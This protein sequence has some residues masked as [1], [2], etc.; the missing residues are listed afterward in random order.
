[1]PNQ[2]QNVNDNQANYR[3]SSSN[4]NVVQSRQIGVSSPGQVNINNS[5]PHQ[6][7]QPAPNNS[8]PI[9]SYLSNQSTNFTATSNQ[10]HPI[11]GQNI[12]SPSVYRPASTT[13]PQY[14]A[15]SNTRQQPHNS[16]INTSNTNASI[17]PSIQ[18]NP[19]VNHLVNHTNQNNNN[20]ARY[21]DNVSNRAGS[22]TNTNSHIAANPISDNVAQANTT[23]HIG[24]QNPSSL[25]LQSSVQNTLNTQ[26]TQSTLPKIEYINPNNIKIP[27]RPESYADL[28]TQAIEND[29]PL[30]TQAT[31]V[32]KEQYNKLQKQNTK[33][34]IDTHEIIK[35][36]LYVLPVIA[37][38]IIIF[39]AP[40]A[41][42][43]LWHARQ[44]VIAQI[45]WLLVLYILNSTGAP[46]IAGNGFTLA[47]LWNVICITN[48]VY[49]GAQAYLG[50]KH[51]I[52]LVYDIASSFIEQD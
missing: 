47:T 32:Y 36:V 21:F 25:N 5:Q 52:P 1:M 19:T 49:A 46:L 6:M 30:P 33:L 29:K 42:E 34:E 8:L 28:K 51:K 35:L 50:N 38:F 20:Y 11:P 14:T 41:E 12:S 45:F 2:T 26:N 43:V 39:K 44:S 9:H 13:S 37:V 40:N 23:Q 48:L 16:T 27:H 18:P 17:A 24:T 10:T 31:E 3:Y 7:P 4:N 22:S 15:V